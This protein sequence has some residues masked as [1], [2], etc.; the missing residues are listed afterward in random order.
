MA[1]VIYDVDTQNDFILEDGA[2][3]VPG[4]EEIVGNLEKIMNLAKEKKILVLGSV[5]SHG[6]D[7]P[8]FES[9][10][11]HCVEGTE[12]QKKIP[13]TIVC[14]DEEIY[15]IP[16]EGK[17]VDK[18]ILFNS[19]QVY[20]EKQT[21]NIWERCL[22]QPDN[23]NTILMEEQIDDVYVIG[24]ASNICVLAAVEGFVENK[25]KVHVITDAIKGLEISDTDNEHTAL[26]RMEE[27][28][29]NFITTD[30]FETFV[31]EKK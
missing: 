25:Y 23:L 16:N 4:A 12:G 28:K 9:Y 17:G 2:L 13:Q 10:P 3:A 31:K 20:L 26:K 8:E 5:D 24:V 18:E 14:K 11:P 21:Y 30:E 7:D 27:L 22:G 1:F 15:I 6:E 19:W 29:V